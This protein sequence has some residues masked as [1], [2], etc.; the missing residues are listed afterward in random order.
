MIGAVDAGDLPVGGG[1]LALLRP[2][3]DRMPPGGVLTVLAGDA[4]AAQD[5]ESWCRLARH[6]FLGAQTISGRAG[7]LIRR[8]PHPVLAPVTGD[9]IS[10]FAPPG[11]LH[12]SAGPRYPFAPAT[13]APPEAAALYDQACRAQWD[14]ARD[15]AWRDIP[16]RAGPLEDA[17][18]Q[19]MSFLAEN[20][21]SALYVPARFL[22]R[23]HPVM[24]PVAQ[25]LGSQLADEA[26]HI[27]A[28]LRRARHGEAAPPRSSPVTAWSLHALLAVD[29]FVEASFLLSV[30]GEG[31]FLDLLRFIE[32]HAPDEPT[33]DLVRRAH[34]DETRHV[35]FGMAHVKHALAR[36]PALAARLEAAV[37]R[38]AAGLASQGVPEPVADALT[39]L[40]AGGADPRA[41]ARGHAAYR[42]LLHTMAEA[43]ARRLLAAGF[44]ADQ[45]RTLAELHTPNFM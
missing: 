31:T 14:P 41:V 38:R 39:I 42:E 16:R 19:V 3:L 15:I 21:L 37:R 18:A 23:L 5:L 22:P 8:G 34:A 40:A 2:V 20:E 30:L 10:G 29:D 17:V 27:E 35:H 4:G 43:R 9:P 7:Y 11:A 45:A 28:F 13:E 1:L 12:E 6:E 26:R 32:I 24:L 44:T 36:D 25:F 33:R